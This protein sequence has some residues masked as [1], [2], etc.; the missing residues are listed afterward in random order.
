[1]CRRNRTSD[2]NIVF[3]NIFLSYEIVGFWGI[4][5]LTFGRD[6]G[7]L[8]PLL[9]GA[10]LKCRNQHMGSMNQRNVGEWKKHKSRSR[11]HRKENTNQT[12]GKLDSKQQSQ[13]SLGGWRLYSG[14]WHQ[15]SVTERFRYGRDRM[16]PVV[17]D[18]K[19]IESSDSYTFATTNNS[20]PFSR[21]HTISTMDPEVSPLTEIDQSYSDPT[22]RLPLTCDLLIIQ[23]RIFST[24]WDPKVQIV[25][26]PAS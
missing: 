19:S 1:M 25:T 21:A 8:I 5:V 4:M 17:W 16:D 13:I 14:Q 6:G 3:M 22:Q 26:R 10:P 15:T 7:H 12:E 20:S 23:Y 18:A 9:I 2:C 24:F 11:R